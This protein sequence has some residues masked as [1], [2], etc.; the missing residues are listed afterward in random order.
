MPS[1]KTFDLPYA[2]VDKSGP[3]HLLIGLDG[4]LS[5][6]LSLQNPVVRYSASSLAYEEF[7]QL[8]TNVVKVLGDGYLLQK[9]DVIS[10]NRY[11]FK[12]PR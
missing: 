1:R 8:M 7:H 10:Q 9:H 12:S 6:I 3:E 2:G 11:P 4:S 5:I